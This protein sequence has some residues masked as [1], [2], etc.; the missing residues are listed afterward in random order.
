MWHF[1]NPTVVSCICSTNGWGIMSSCSRNLKVIH[2]TSSTGASVEPSHGLEIQPQLANVIWHL[3]DS[4]GTCSSTG[5]CVGTWIVG[6]SDVGCICGDAGAASWGCDD[7]AHS[8][9]SST[10]SIRWSSLGCALWAGVTGAIGGG[11]AGG[12]ALL[13]GEL[14]NGEQGESLWISMLQFCY[15]NV[16]IIQVLTYFHPSQGHCQS[17]RCWLQ[18][19]PRG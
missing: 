4:V 13:V 14:D 12:C 3:L 8:E 9:S 16:I 17:C 10:V 18:Q 1:I 6:V 19:E 2:T 15:L 5:R 7:T 11:G